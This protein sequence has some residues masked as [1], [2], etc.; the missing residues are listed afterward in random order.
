M[1][2]KREAW[3][4][5]STIFSSSPPVDKIG[6]GLLTVKVRL[7]RVQNLGGRFNSSTAVESFEDETDKTEGLLTAV[8]IWD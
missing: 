8:G 4:I 6:G 3:L 1:A 5:E 2:Q 7:P